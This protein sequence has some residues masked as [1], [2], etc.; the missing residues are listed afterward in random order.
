[1]SDTL[2]MQ[3]VNLIGIPNNF[4]GWVLIYA[5][6]T[7]L[8]TVFIVLIFVLPFTVFSRR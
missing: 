6:M 3:V 2:I 7:V 8:L 1:M 5:M 4:A